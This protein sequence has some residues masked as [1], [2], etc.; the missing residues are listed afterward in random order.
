[1]VYV[2]TKQKMLNLTKKLDNDGIRCKLIYDCCCTVLK[3]EEPDGTTLTCVG[4]VPI[5]DS[6]VPK[7]LKKLRL[8]E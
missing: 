4:I 7:Y 5:N 3:P 2:K 1:V 6:K 8:L